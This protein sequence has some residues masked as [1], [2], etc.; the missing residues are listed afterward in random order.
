MPSAANEC[1]AKLARYSCFDSGRPESLV[2]EGET[3]DLQVRRRFGMPFSLPTYIHRYQLRLKQGND[4][5]G[6]CMCL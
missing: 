3:G 2:R 1:V 4:K 5:K 6:V